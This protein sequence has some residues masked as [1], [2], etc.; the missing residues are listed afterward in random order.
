MGM[1]PFFSDNENLS[2]IMQ[3]LKKTK[4][5]SLFELSINF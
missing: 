2:V 4:F 5:K 3:R 1:K